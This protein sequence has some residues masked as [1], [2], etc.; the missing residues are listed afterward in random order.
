MKRFPSRFM[1]GIWWLSIV[2]LGSSYSG[3]LMS[4]M[5][6]PLTEK[7]P[8]TFDQLANSILTGEY[9][10]GVASTAILWQAIENSKLK[11][12]KIISNHIIQNNNFMELNKGIERVEKERFALIFSD[13]VLKK[14][15]WKNL[16]NFVFSNDKLFTFMEAYAMRKSFP[17]RHQIHEIFRTVD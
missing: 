5:T 16:N 7:V 15:L 10:C 17:F 13:Y 1:I 11:S 14:K 8:N 9:S 3:T 2:I 6:Y 4:F 12:A